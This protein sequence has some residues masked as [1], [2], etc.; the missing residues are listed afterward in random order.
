MTT[1]ERRTAISNRAAESL[2][3]FERSW[4]VYHQVV[5]SDG[6]EHAGLA[7]AL[8]RRLIA[9]VAAR[10]PAAPLRLVDL[11]CGDLTTLAPL[12]RQLPLTAFTAVDAA[13][14]VLPRAAATLGATPWP[15]RWQAADLLAWALAPAAGDDD[16]YELI[17][18]L[19]GLHHL[20]DADKWRLLESLPQRLA[21]GGLV[22]I[23][24]VFRPEGESRPAYV[25]RYRRRVRGW[26]EIGAD[27]QDLV[28]AHLESSDFPADRAE[29]VVRAAAAGWCCSWLWNGHHAAEALL[30]I[31]RPVAPAATSASAP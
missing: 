17:T 20:A 21:P 4:R 7:A 25:E 11:A 16:R 6:M 30:A 29:F 15:C 31:S 3:L 27:G 8:E 13:A 10:P 1:D 19:F 2:D 12:L 22:L 5:A 23:G 14:G 24:D 26:Q 9:Y 28:I 18:C